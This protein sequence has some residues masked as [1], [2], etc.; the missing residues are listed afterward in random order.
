MD[1]ELKTNQSEN[2]NKVE[3]NAQDYIDA[4]NDLKK[5]S[6][7]RSDYEKLK[8]E[9][10]K[11]I[12]AVVNG[13]GI[14]EDHSQSR[15]LEEI[16]KELDTK[17]LTNLDFWKDQLEYRNL[18]LKKGM[19]DP[20]LNWGIKTSPTESDR[21]CADRVA[22]VVQECIDYADGNPEVFNSKLYSE[23]RG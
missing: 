9:N 5:N 1:E 12:E 16:K 7:N 3:D 17:Q 6:V 10:K 14:E 8:A 13:Q 19:P 23:I 21:E 18:A 2:G 15:T 20:F 4:I 11:L 22:R